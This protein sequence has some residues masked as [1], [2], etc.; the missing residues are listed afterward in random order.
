MWLKDVLGCQESYFID[1]PYNRV[2]NLNLF[3]DD[4]SESVSVISIEISC[5]KN[6]GLWNAIVRFIIFAQRA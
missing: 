4:L 6:S 3:S 1:R 5:H 2:S